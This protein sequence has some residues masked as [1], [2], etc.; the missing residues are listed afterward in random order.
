MRAEGQRTCGLC[1]KL[2]FVKQNQLFR[3][4]EARMRLTMFLCKYCGESEVVE[5][6]LR[7]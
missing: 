4:N 3:K 2:Q 6:A 5:A 1:G 7:N